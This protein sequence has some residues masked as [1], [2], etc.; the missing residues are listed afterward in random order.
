MES[1]RQTKKPKLSDHLLE[2]KFMQR[3]QQKLRIIDENARHLAIN[4]ESQWWLNYDDVEIGKPKL[5][6]KYSPSY[7][8]CIN[9]AFSGRMSFGKSSKNDEIEAPVLPEI[10][11]IEDDDDYTP[12]VRK[13]DKFKRKREESRTAR[14]ARKKR[15]IEVKSSE[16]VNERKREENQTARKKRAIEVKS[17]ENVNERNDSIQVTQTRYNLRSR[18]RQ[19]TSYQDDIEMITSSTRDNLNIGFLKPPE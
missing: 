12:F 16:N 6:V 1:E 18:K 10:I 13:F 4:G 3:T 15:A 14:S 9:A 5:N 2:L 8:S 11:T 17:S 19:P 7:F